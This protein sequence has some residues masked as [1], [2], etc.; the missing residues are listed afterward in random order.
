MV[1]T[2]RPKLFGTVEVDKTYIGG[3]EHGA[4][5]GKVMGNK[6]LFAIAVELK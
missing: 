5:S 1:R 4:S 6:V 3:E 2:N